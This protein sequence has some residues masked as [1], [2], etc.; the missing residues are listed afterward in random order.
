M[1]KAGFE[2]EGKGT[3]QEGNETWRRPVGLGRGSE[4]LGQFEF[5]RLYGEGNGQL[6][7]FLPGPH[8]AASLRE[9]PRIS[10]SSDQVIGLIGL[11]PHHD[12][13]T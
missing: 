4:W 13:F 3:V 1:I 9:W 7:V 11:G 10:F 8:V 12:D 5:E 2:S 6:A